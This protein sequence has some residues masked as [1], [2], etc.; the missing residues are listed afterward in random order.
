MISEIL[1]KFG[2]SE[3]S[4]P[5]RLKCNRSIT[6]FLGPNNSGKSQILREISSLCSGGNPEANVILNKIIFDSV[7]HGDAKEF[8]NNVKA[9]PSLG[10]HHVPEHILCRAKN[11]DFWVSEK[12]YYSVTGKI[13]ESD[14]NDFSNF[15]QWYAKHNYLMLDGASR[16]NL[17]APQDRG[18]LTRPT[19]AFTKILL[20]SAKRQRISKFLLESTNLHFALDI[21]DGGLIQIRFGK[22]P[23]VD[24]RN[25]NDETVTYMANAKPIA[26]MSDGIKALTGILIQINAGFEKTI[27]IDEPEAFLHPSLAFKLGK[28]ISTTAIQEN[29]A[30]FVSTHSP[31]FLMGAIASG[32]NINI[33]R[34]TYD[35]NVG[36][37]RLLENSQLR[38]LMNDP[39]LRSTGVLEGLFLSDISALETKQC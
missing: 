35:G 13:N 19:S 39:L 23:P 15:A 28:E 11:S 24:E 3:N 18:N 6:V 16:I 10:Q 22:S 21:T 29:K 8:I 31:Q 5:L 34:M 9:T 32:V 2:A 36:S 38:E 33:V 1:L 37:A 12:K 30:I 17:I 7:K 14:S 27:L 26:D 4:D 25:L 20:E